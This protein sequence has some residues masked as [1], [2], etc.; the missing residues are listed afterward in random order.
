MF[1]LE[2]VRSVVIEQFQTF[3]FPKD[4]ILLVKIK[5]T[6]NGLGFSK[7]LQR[8]ATTV[9]GLMVDSFRRVFLAYAQREYPIL[10][11]IALSLGEETPHYQLL[12]SLTL[13]C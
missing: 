9:Y 5:E 3:F 13:P 6:G 1:A 12:T 11:F 2:T 7:T 8:A 10:E 4:K